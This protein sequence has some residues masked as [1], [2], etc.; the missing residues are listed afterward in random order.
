MAS[1]FFLNGEEGTVL[2]PACSSVCRS[3]YYASLDSIC[4]YLDIFIRTVFAVT[5]LPQT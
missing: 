5:H 4:V 1:L 2:G 3:F